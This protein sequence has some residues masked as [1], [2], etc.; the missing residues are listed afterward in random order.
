MVYLDLS[1][2]GLEVIPDDVVLALASNKCLQVF[3]IAGNRLG[4]AGV[5]QLSKVFMSATKTSVLNTFGLSCN[6]LSSDSLLYF[7]N[8]LTTWPTKLREISI[9]ENPLV[10]YTI[11]KD[12]LQK[13]FNVVIIEPSVDGAMAYA[14]YLSEM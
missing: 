1:Y 11:V 7:A 12:S 14:D 8:V 9:C 4:D 3:R 13:V 10:E 2:C 6:R 5:F